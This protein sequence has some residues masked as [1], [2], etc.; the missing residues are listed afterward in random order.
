[1][2]VALARMSGGERNRLGRLAAGSHGGDDRNDGW[3]ASALRDDDLAGIVLP[4]SIGMLAKDGEARASRRAGT[5][6]DDARRSRTVA[7]EDLHRE[8]A[9]RGGQRTGEG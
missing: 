6:Y 3:S 7:P 4:P 5:G 1:M 8:A 9:G 2:A